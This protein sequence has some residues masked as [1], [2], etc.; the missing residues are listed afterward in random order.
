MSDYLK[1]NKEVIKLPGKIVK[2]LRNEN[3]Q[4][5]LVY[6]II[7]KPDE[8]KPIL[9]T[10]DFIYNNLREYSIE[11]TNENTIFFILEND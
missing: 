7:K 2:I 5:D 6:F 9:A 11:G 10:V 4:T 8:D 1:K 3:S